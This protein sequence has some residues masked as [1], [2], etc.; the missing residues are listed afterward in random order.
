MISKQHKKDYDDFS[1]YP[2]ASLFFKYVDIL[3]SHNFYKEA[4][5]L[6]VISEQHYLP[7]NRNIITKIIIEMQKAAVSDEKN[8]FEQ[9]LR[10]LQN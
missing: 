10:Q 9:L 7:E 2:L 1:E 8:K 5:D 3:K 6:L 4:E